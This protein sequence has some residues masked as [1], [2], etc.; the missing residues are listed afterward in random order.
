MRWLRQHKIITIFCSIVFLVIASIV[1]VAAIMWKKLDLI[2]YDIKD[3]TLDN[4]Q[5]TTVN[6]FIENTQ[7]EFDFQSYQIQGNSNN[8]VDEVLTV[9]NV[10]NLIVLDGEPVLPDG[11]IF[12]DSDILNILL[13]GTDERSADFSD[14]ARSDSMILLSIN[15]ED[16]SLKLISLERGMGVPVLDG[17]YEGQYDWL[18]HIFRY[19]GADLLLETVRTCLNIDVYYYVRVNFN[20]MTQII[21]SV[22]GV[23]IEL[24]QAEADYLHN[25]GQVGIYP[26]V[27]VGLNHLSGAEA[28]A[29][30]RIRK[31]DSDWQRV[32]RQ[33]NVI[34][35]IVYS[36]KGLGLL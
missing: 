2:Q 19:G 1:F 25:N 4:V 18:T 6:G 24:T 26:D 15:Q 30:S 27:V 33:R 5:K 20:T 12:K 35:E 17:I 13:I 7:K 28:L 8:K 29:Y 32:Q 23:E 14:N 3:K 9:E 31:I 36:A 16:K 10:E 11:E 34:Q 21:D 22:G